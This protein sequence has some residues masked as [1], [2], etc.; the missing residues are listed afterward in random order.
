MMKKEQIA[1][2]LYLY[3]FPPRKP[4][5]NFGYNIFAL[6]DEDRKGALLIDTA[7]KDHASTV[8]KDLAANGYTVQ[9]A[10]ISHF[11]DDHILG[12]KALSRVAVLGSRLCGPLL[13]WEDEIDRSDCAPTGFVEDVDS[14]TFGEFT[15]RF[16][17]APGRSDCTIYTIIDE[18]YVHVADNLMSSNDGVPI[19]PWA[20]F[21]DVPEHIRS[22]EK[23]GEFKTHTLLLSHGKNITGESVV[24]AEI[25]NRMKYLQAVLAG[26]GGISYEQAVKN[27]SC[28]F[29]HNEWHIRKE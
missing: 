7:F 2:N 22:L 8:M 5:H 29:L 24:V 10:V 1:E 18:R 14:V 6:L 19:L 26:E 27:C 12:L 3:Q 13:E 20:L 17:S 23:L 21:D 16:L 9:K 28:D 25:D 11:H 4:E 15:L